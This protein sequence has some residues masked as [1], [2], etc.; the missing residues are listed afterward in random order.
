MF[1][2]SRISK[3]ILASTITALLASDASA[4]NYYW[5]G[6][7]SSVW[8]LAANWSSGSLLGITYTAGPGPTGSTGAHRLS[9]HNGAANPLIYDATLGTTVYANTTGRGLVLGSGTAAPGGTMIITGGTFSTAGSSAGDVI[10]NSTTSGTVS[11]LTV[12][13]G[14]YISAN[15][16]LAVN[17]GGTN[18]VGNFNIQN[19]TA[20]VTTLTV[21]TSA[22]GTGT[23]NLDGGTLAVN[24]VNRTGAGAGTFNFNGG[25]LQARQANA[26]FMQGLTAANVKSGGATIDTNNF[27]VTIGQSLLDGTGGGGLT[28]NSAG[29]LTLTGA[30][31]YT[32]TT[33]ISAGT[34]ELG[35]GGATGSIGGGAVVN[36]GTLAINRT[37]TLGFSAGISGSGNVTI[38][39]GATVNLGGTNTYAGTT[40]VNA[41]LLNLNGTATTD[42]TI[43]NGANLGGEGSTTGSLTFAGTSTLFF[44]PNSGAKLT[45]ASVNGIAGTVT[46]SLTSGSPA[47]T[48]ILVLEAAG[49]ITGTAGGLGNNF[50]FTGRGTSYL[51]AGNTQLLIDYTPASLKWTG[52]DVTNPTF[53][54]TNATA[55]WSNGGSSDVFFAGDSLT[56][57]DTAT[58]FAVAVQG[59]SVEPGNTVVSNTLNPYTFSGGAIGGTGTL[60]KSGTNSLTISNTNTFTGGTTITAG[61][62]VASSL[63]ALGSGAVN[64]GAG[65]VL[66]LTFGAGT[67]TT[68]G[69]SGAGTVNVT[70]GTA[71]A[72]T[73]LNG[74]NSGFTGTM[75]IG[76][77][78]AG[79]GKAQ[80]SGELGA[81]ATVNVLP[82][83]TL[84][85]AG[86]VTQPASVVLNGGDTG[87]SLGQLRIE[88][89]V[90]WSGNITL[91]GDATGLG[92]G[93]L[94]SSLGIST[95]SGVVSE[96]GGARALTKVG[97]GTIALT[98][99]NT[100]TGP[101][102]ILGGALNIQN[103]AALGTNN[104]VTVAN[105]AALEIQ[106]N[107]TIA[108]KALSITGGGGG[109]GQLGALRSISG[110]NAWN[111]DITAIPSG[112]VTRIS[113][114]AGT[115]TIN[116]NIATTGGA[117]DLLV[118]QGSGQ[119]TVNGI[120]SGASV[121]NGSSNGTAT[122]LRTLTGANTYTGQTRING[123]ILSV[124]SIN[125]VNSGLPSN[126][127]MPVDAASGTITIG[128][129]NGAGTL[130]YTG[131]GETTDRII[132]L[133]GSVGNGGTIEASGTA[134]LVFST[135]AISTGAVAKTMTLTGTGDGVF[136]AG[137]AAATG[138]I[139]VVKTGSGKWTIGGTST[140]TG[141]TAIDSGTLMVAGTLPA[142]STTTITGG[143]LSGSGF[144]GPII[145]NG[146]NVAPGDGTGILT[147]NGNVALNLGS[148]LAIQINGNTLGTDYDQFAVNGTVALTD[149]TLSL[150]GSFVPA[151]NDL[152]F[153]LINDGLDSITGTL[154]GLG[155]G[156]HVFGQN[157][158][159]F[160]ITYNAEFDNGTFTGGNDIA[161]M[162]VPE[163]GSAALLLGG[164]GLLG[165]RRRRK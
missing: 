41:G 69:L 12:N 160:V 8:G 61:S 73:V 92:D 25:I 90:T 108:D 111:S 85:V 143:T 135:A 67:Y 59:A 77:G 103:G 87:E 22:G 101:T 71:A 104:A 133:V 149:A 102:S 145:A 144:T 33:T 6:S 31:T 3:S 152:F 75:N 11:T 58:S 27:D 136:S 127:G 78:A 115:L 28:K 5:D 81:S 157:G 163:P 126:L 138:T 88:N 153:V 47:A 110:T 129:A 112:T 146:G 62:I 52:S 134:P 63:G 113:V 96:S 42:I 10:G 139:S 158:Q 123:G 53:W 30:S 57:D 116:G 29:K 79:A 36:N 128:S 32:G 68:N 74:S 106:G 140:Y 76:T 55:N 99:A 162:A 137:I 91:A 9:V 54:N 17:F 86:A 44:N 66:D 24:L 89:G 142:A 148:T 72:T 56:F 48:G 26:T 147:A 65:A 109:G 98:N 150:S 151:Q 34:L 19:G 100:Y 38:A 120:I 107:V 4:L 1:K 46:L 131:P 37:G 97:A 122:S 60:T 13:G 83:A 49:G 117:A 51:A 21:S 155:E 23:V 35:N 130:R 154:A 119:M 121:L 16:G 165:A 95:I 80:L 39:G 124:A 156:S 50:I 159:D 125:S 64:V 132:S 118:L 14:N 114:D 82:N 93:L 161:L 70:L 40:A 7:D 20:T 94:G 84:Y 164:L 43:A 105:G 141:T 2:K 15:S 45:A 18:N